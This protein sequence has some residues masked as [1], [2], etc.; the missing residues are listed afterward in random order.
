MSGKRRQ[1]Q[2][3][4]ARLSS[5][6][7]EIMAK[8]SPILERVSANSSPKSPQNPNPQD[9][10]NMARMYQLP[11]KI[12]FSDASKQNTVPTLPPILLNSSVA[13]INVVCKEIMLEREPA[14][15]TSHDG[16]EFICPLSMVPITIPAR[17]IFCK[18]AQCFDLR[19][20]LLL[21]PEH[22]W[23]CPICHEQLSYDS[24][25]FDPYYFSEEATATPDIQGDMDDMDQLDYFD[26]FY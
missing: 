9:P 23:S 22:N 15:M 25:R 26:S 12:E 8:L 2:L 19:E 13:D 16:V 20:F 17:G 14:P 11:T 10:R 24:L 5:S 7:E 6:P 1:P 4:Q 18:H 21:I 3:R